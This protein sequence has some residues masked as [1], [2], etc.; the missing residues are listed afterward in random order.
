[1]IQSFLVQITTDQLAD[2]VRLNKVSDKVR[3][4]IATSDDCDLHKSS[5][6]IKS[7]ALPN[8]FGIKLRA[9]IFIGENISL[10]IRNY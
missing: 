1:V 5:I 3:T 4:P 8:V 10:V 2:L 9:T 7:L 6:M